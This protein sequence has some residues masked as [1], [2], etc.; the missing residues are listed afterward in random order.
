MQL[1]SGHVTIKSDSAASV[2]SKLSVIVVLSST[3]AGVNMPGHRP[4]T[5]RMAKNVGN[6]A[7]SSVTQEFH[8]ASVVGGSHITHKAPDT[9]GYPS[10]E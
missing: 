9:S 8:R 4:V 3:M 5:R 2:Q 6:G 1:R 10:I 7:G